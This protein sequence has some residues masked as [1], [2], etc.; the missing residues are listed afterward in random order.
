MC[1]AGNGMRPFDAA[2]KQVL[3]GSDT[4]FDLNLRALVYQQQR[5]RITRTH[6]VT[7]TH[8]AGTYTLTNLYSKLFSSISMCVLSMF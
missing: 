7:H 1:L 4:K 8:M 2:G 6:T 3:Y 5:Q